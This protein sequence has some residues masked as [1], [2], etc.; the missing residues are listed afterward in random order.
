MLHG[1]LKPFYFATMHLQQ[2]SFPS[3]SSSKLIANSLIVDFEKRSSVTNKNLN[4][5]L[6]YKVL[7]NNLEKYLYDKIS[8]LQKRATLVRFQHI[9][10]NQCL[11]LFHLLVSSIS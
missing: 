4:E 1:L 5:R 8:E 3:L 7:S 6:L 2:Q 11:F 10:N 9:I